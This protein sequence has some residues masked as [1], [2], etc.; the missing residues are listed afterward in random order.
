MALKAP[1]LQAIAEG[2][3]GHFANNQLGEPQSLN[4]WLRGFKDIVSYNARM[5]ED[6]HTVDAFSDPDETE[7]TIQ[8]S[9][10]SW[11]KRRLL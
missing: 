7:D 4:Y 5:I 3:V 2:I 9:S 6:D 1:A 10:S 11:W 8:R